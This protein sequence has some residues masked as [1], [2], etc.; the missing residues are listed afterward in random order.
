MVK[1]LVVKP[2]P[3]MA[4]LSAV[5]GECSPPRTWGAVAQ[6]VPPNFELINV[7]ST[8]IHGLIRLLRGELNLVSE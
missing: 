6:V 7:Q 2:V 5:L 8:D 1:A 4:P 3:A